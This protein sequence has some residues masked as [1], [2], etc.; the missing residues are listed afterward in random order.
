MVRSGDDNWKRIGS[1]ARIRNRL[2]AD[3]LRGHDSKHQP[4]KN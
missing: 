1:A 2:L 3:R 4:R